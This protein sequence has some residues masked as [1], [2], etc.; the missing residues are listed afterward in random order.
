MAGMNGGGAFVLVY[1]ACVVLVGLPI[2]ISEILLGRRGRRN[3]VA[4]ME[5]L[6]EEESGTTAWRWVGLMG[7]VAGFII[8]SF[9][10]VIAGWTAAYIFKAAGGAFRGADA[11]ALRQMFSAFIGNPLITGFWH[12]LFMTV[13]VILVGL[14]F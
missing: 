2:M 8:L 11:G 9:Y 3:P 1:L 14:G 12:T 13:T 5:I 7:V 4:T 10:S 6:G